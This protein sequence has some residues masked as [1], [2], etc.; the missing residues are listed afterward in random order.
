MNR[1]VESDQNEALK[2][3]ERKV[4]SMLLA[5]GPE[6]IDEFGLSEQYFSVYKHAFLVIKSSKGSDRGEVYIKLKSLGYDFDDE[7][8]E[9]GQELGIDY[10][11]AFINSLKEKIALQEARRILDQSLTS[12]EGLGNV[13]VALDKVKESLENNYPITKED[14]SLSIKNVFEETVNRIENPSTNYKFFV[15][16]MDHKLYDFTAGNTIV[17]GARPSVGKTSLSLWSALNLA[18]TG[19]PVHFLS[20]EMSVWQIGAKIFSLITGLPASRL[21]SKISTEEEKNRLKAIPRMFPWLPF[22]LTSISI[23]TMQNIEEIM[24]KSV[25]NYGT[26]VFFIDYVQ[27]IIHPRYNSTRHQEVAYIVQKLKNLAIELDVAIVELSQLSR[28]GNKDPEM[29]HLKESGDIEQA[30]SLIIL[31]WKDEDGEE[32][33]EEDEEESVFDPD[34]FDDVEDI[35]QI[36]KRIKK[37][38]SSTTESRYRLVNYRVEKHRNGPTFSGKLIFDSESSIFYDPGKKIEKHEEY[39]RKLISFAH[40]KSPVGKAY[41][42]VLQALDSNSDNVLY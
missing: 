32:D 13:I 26:K 36:G 28:A 41:Y 7:V 16:Y 38:S 14:S 24:R 37:K 33:K 35:S 27:L 3:L 34:E 4:I 39:L 19:V 23:P 15:G 1:K 10:A 40:S 9:S 18:F 30:A 20:L 2:D 8:V 21:F 31:L 17:I 29:S 6:Y 12:D 42:S 25:K 22:R 11:K 5:F